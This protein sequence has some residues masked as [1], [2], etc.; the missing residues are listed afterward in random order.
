[1]YFQQFFSQFPEI[2][3]ATV[4]RLLVL[5]EGM[6]LP[7]GD[8]DF[9]NS[10]CNDYKCDCRRVMVQVFHKN[11]NE[12]WMQ[13]ATLSYGWEPDSFYYKWSKAMDANQLKWFKGPEIEP[14]QPQSKYA[15]ITLSYFKEMLKDPE[16]ANRFIR[17]YALFKWKLGMKLPKD[18]IPR[19][20]MM[21]PCPCKSEKLLKFCCALK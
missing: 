3:K 10:Y 17:E 6:D 1:M 8:Y 7:E 21:E 16:Y 19:L 14:F 13:V 11:I 12:E 4:R 20:K 18:L 5:G 15:A 2:A 9:I